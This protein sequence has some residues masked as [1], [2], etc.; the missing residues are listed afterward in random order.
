MP[1]TKSLGMNI[2]TASNPNDDQM[3]PFANIFKLSDSPEQEDWGTGTHA[4]PVG[5]QLDSAGYYRY[6]VAGKDYVSYI[7]ARTN[8]IAAMLLQSS[9]WVIK[10]DGTGTATMLGCSGSPSSG[11]GRL[12]FTPTGTDPLVLLITG[13]PASP[14]NDNHMRNIRILPLSEEDSTAIASTPLK[15]KLA[16]FAGGVLRPMQMTGVNSDTPWDPL[17]EDRPL[18]TDSLW[19]DRNRGCPITAL[20]K[21]AWECGMIPWITL[22]HNCIGTGSDPDGADFNYVSNVV[23]EADTAAASAPAPLR[24]I[25]WEF[26]NE[27][28]FNQQYKSW[29]DMRDRGAIFFNSGDVF[30]DAA[31]FYCALAFRVAN[32]IQQNYTGSEPLHLCVLGAMFEENQINSTIRAFEYESATASTYFDAVAVAPYAFGRY[33]MS[34]TTP[35]NGEADDD[36]GKTI[37]E[38]IIAIGQAATVTAIFAKA[39]LDLPAF[40]TKAQTI[41]T[42]WAGTFMPMWYYEGP[43]IHLLFGVATPPNTYNFLADTDFH[44][45]IEA[46]ISDARIFQLTKDVVNAAYSVCDGPACY[47][48]LAG[49]RTS[50]N[51]AGMFG[52]LKF[53]SSSVSDAESTQYRA[54]VDL[55]NP[56]GGSGSGIGPKKITGKFTSSKVTSKKVSGV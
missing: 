29:Q 26:G 19:S 39:A 30:I 4:P 35:A 11:S 6:I 53:V 54:L 32:F 34:R 42:A 9:V 5:G 48:N 12:E 31:S 14:G 55:L 10:W 23:E 40:A 38:N 17:S 7:V 44:A 24:K 50:P 8:M 16:P 2:G 41:K 15:Q 45:C 20:C 28:C 43:S 33:G 52:S 13:L 21:L 36:Y 25:V 27:T 22:S 51:C 3:M 46:F 1:L 49:Q 47:F 18:E 56:G 37:K